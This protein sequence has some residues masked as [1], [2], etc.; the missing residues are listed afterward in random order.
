MDFYI[1]KDEYFSNHFTYISM[2]KVLK[3]VTKNYDVTSDLIDFVILG[4]NRRSLKTK[5]LGTRYY[6]RTIV[7]GVLTFDS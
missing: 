4:D 5:S 6:I 2:S 7:T 3:F 1:I